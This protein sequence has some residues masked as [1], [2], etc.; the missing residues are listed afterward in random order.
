MQSAGA[1]KSLVLPLAEERR[2]H[3]RVKVNLLG[4]YMLE[5]Q[6]EYPCQV[7]NMS[8]GG[9]IIITPVTGTVGERV[10]A[11]VDQIGRI[12]GK[13]VRL[14]ENG[15]AMTISATVRKR[16]KLAA[17]LTWLANRETLN[18]VEERR[19]GRF[20]P[21]NPSARLVLPSG[22]NLACRVIDLSQSGAAVSVADDLRPPVGA[23]VTLGKVQGRVVRHIENGFAIEFTR[24][25]H[26]DLVEES[27][28]GE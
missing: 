3:Q 25:Q 12:E 24:L 2:R 27:V 9:M 18:L 14:I 10:I 11:Y 6:H 4:R 1:N 8:P 16:D 5:N 23:M 22:K 13:I 19:H 21:K 26:P 20:A 28:T 17:Q 15:F 7:V